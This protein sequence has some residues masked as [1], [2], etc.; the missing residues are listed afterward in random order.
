MAR[1]AFLLV[2][3]LT[4]LTTGYTQEVSEQKKAKRCGDSAV[5]GIRDATILSMM[6][7]GLGLGVGIATLCALI[8]SSVS[9]THAH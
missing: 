9:T 6:G 1:L 5:C 7:W 3:F 4:T 8:P 2:L